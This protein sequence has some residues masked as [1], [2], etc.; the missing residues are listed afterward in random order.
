[1]A[2]ENK[3]RKAKNSYLDGGAEKQFGIKLKRLFYFCKQDRIRNKREIRDELK[4]G[5]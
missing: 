4:E 5:E 1:M 3:K 2:S